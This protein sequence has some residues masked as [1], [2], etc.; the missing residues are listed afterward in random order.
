MATWRNRKCLSVL[1]TRSTDVCARP[2]S[3]NQLNPR[4]KELLGHIIPPLLE[5]YE[6]EDNKYVPGF[7]FPFYPAAPAQFGKMKD[8][9]QLTSIPN[10]RV[11]RKL[12]F[13]SLTFTLPS[14]ACV[15]FEFNADIGLR[16]TSTGRSYLHCVSRLPRPSPSLGPRSWRTVSAKPLRLK[17]TRNSPSCPCRC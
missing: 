13:C 8:F 4:V 14:K 3:Q 5:M 7:L 6:T 17:N 11:R 9:T 10:R 16:S 15:L 12:D 1:V 2:Y